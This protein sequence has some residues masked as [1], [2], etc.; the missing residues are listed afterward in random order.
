MQRHIVQ[1]KPDPADTDSMVR[2][3]P[4]S[5][6]ASLSAAIER[7]RNRPVEEGLSSD[8]QAFQSLLD[9]AKAGA[10]WAW[11]QIYREFYGVVTGYLAS[12]G[13][14]DPDGLTGDVLFKVAG[15]IHTFEGD[16]ASFRSWV[17]VIAHRSLIDERRKLGRRPVQT[18]LP[19]E[20]PGGDVESE[21]MERLVTSEL[22]AAFSE[23][24][25]GQRDVLSLRI[26]A[27]LTLEEAAQVLEMT[28]GAVKATQ[29]RAIGNLRQRL[30]REGT[31]M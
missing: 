3:S 17:F 2:A 6:R 21:A 14:F 24:T 23:L 8:G 5:R 20:A 7:R 30:E 13:S 31:V 29:H 10:E 18:E 26:I 28:V 16:S 19:T 11:E 22:M 15:S 25:E 9:A 4:F 12:R 1:K 27:G